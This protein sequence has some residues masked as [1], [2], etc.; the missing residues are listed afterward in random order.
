MDS[1][2]VVQLPSRDGRVITASPIANL[3]LIMSTTV[4]NENEPN[5]AHRQYKIT[6]RHLMK[7]DVQRVGPPCPI[8]GDE[9]TCLLQAGEDVPEWLPAKKLDELIRNMS[10]MDRPNQFVIGCNEKIDELV[11]E[12]LLEAVGI[13]ADKVS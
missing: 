5:L 2:L 10:T 1:T 13:D 11:R 7:I 3:N 12:M 4:E 6:V 8:F 9:K